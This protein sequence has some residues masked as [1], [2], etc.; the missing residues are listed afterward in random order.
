MITMVNNEKKARY[1]SVLVRS[2]C[3]Q[4]HKQTDDEYSREWFQDNAG[5]WQS[6]CWRKQHVISEPVRKCRVERIYILPKHHLCYFHCV[7]DPVY[8]PLPA[9]ARDHV[10]H[11][12]VDLEH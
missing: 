2:A 1:I 9:R 5:P 10:F 6:E 12:R 11:L 4:A 3:L 8:L 7:S